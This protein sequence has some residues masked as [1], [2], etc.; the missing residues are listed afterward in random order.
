MVP[1]LLE[2]TRTGGCCPRGYY[3]LRWPESLLQEDNTG[4]YQG[5]HRPGRRER[6][7]QVFRAYRHPARLRP[8]G[9]RLLLSRYGLWC[10]GWLNLA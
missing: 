9:H 2:S 4:D 7:K 5:R 3:A 1:Q 8:G 6:R 10:R